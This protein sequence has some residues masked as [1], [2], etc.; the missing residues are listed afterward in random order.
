MTDAPKTLPRAYTPS[1]GTELGIAARL[2]LRTLR[3]RLSGK[4]EKAPDLA[5]FRRFFT[6]AVG[7]LSPGTLVDA[8]LVDLPANRA[9]WTATG[10][11]LDAGDKVT[12][13]AMGRVDMAK[14]LDVWVAPPFQFWAKVGDGPVF[15]G[16]RA[17][18]SYV[19]DHGGDLSLASYF[20]GEWASPDGR[21]G[22]DPADFAAMGGG[23][24]AAVLVWAVP[25]EEGLLR[26]AALGD[27]EGL[28]AGELDRLRHAKAPPAG[29]KH[30]WYLG[31]SE[32]FF[33]C[34]EVGRAR[35]IGCVTHRDVAILQYDVEAPLE[36]GLMLE[37]QWKVDRL[38]TSLREDSVPSHDYM[39]IAVEFDN[40]QDLTYYW[41]AA[42]PVGTVYHCPL[43][44]WKD[45]ETHVVLR[46]GPQGLGT[47][48]AEARDVHADYA[49][50]LG[51]TIPGKVIRIWLIANS[52]F[53]RDRG[54]STFAGIELVQGGQR[55][56]VG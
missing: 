14:P 33:R 28:V 53:G 8:K 48:I 19:A 38:P 18:H 15:R 6:E 24:L 56:P 51:G 25:I 36:P 52:L 46:S 31:D 35:A 47:W 49:A 1:K 23:M 30:L 34:E 44:T 2:G 54:E 21:L 27:H 32:T 22:T 4:L 10:I 13:F 37:W 55:I 12:T 43:P 41:S 45:K 39:S 5:A 29:W 42:L 16:T 9:P 11:R 20:P 17:G 3:K 7:K 40:G 50:A 26:L